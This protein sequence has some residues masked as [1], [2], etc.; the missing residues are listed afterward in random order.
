MPPKFHH[1]QTPPVSLGAPVGAFFAERS[2]SLSFACIGVSFLQP[3]RFLKEE[4]DES[5]V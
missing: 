1:G 2:V 3:W 5:L 4:D